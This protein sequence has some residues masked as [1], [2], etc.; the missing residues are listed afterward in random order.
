MK[1]DC[2]SLNHGVVSFVERL[3]RVQSVWLYVTAEAR[4]V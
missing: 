3:F 2:S 4:E 1:L